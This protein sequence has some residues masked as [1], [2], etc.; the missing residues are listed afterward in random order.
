MLS[1]EDVD[2]HVLG[3]GTTLRFVLLLVLV[4]ASSA[5][6]MEDHIIIRRFLGDPN[7]DILGCQLAAGFDPESTFWNTAFHHRNNQALDACV[8]NYGPIWWVPVLVIA[9]LIA[10]TGAL[11]WCLPAWKGRRSRV[12]PV[13]EVDRQ[14]DLRPLLA[15]LVSLAGL[16]RAPHFVVD[17]AT[18]ATS[19]VVFG[20][21][22]RHTVCLHGGLVAR[23]LVDPAGFRGIV[24]HELAHIRNGDVGITYATVALW[25]VFLVAMLLPY[26]A[27]L[28][29]LLVSGQFFTTDS[30]SGVAWPAIVPGLTRG[31]LLSVF[32]VVLVYLSRADILRSREIHADLA[33]VGWGA[34]PEGWHHGAHGGADRSRI[35]EI[36]ASFT[37]LWHTHPRWDRRRRSLTDPSE[38]FGVPAL[39][40]FLT[41][42]AAALVAEHLRFT[43]WSGRA[44]A[45]MAAGLI[46][47]TV[48][49]ALWRAV[50]HAVLTDRRV[51]SG[52][53]AGMWLG[54]GLVAG[55]LLLREGID[56][57]QW[58]PSYPMV[59]LV[60][61]LLAV[62]ATCWTVQC[63]ELWITMSRGRLVRLT[64][65][66]GLVGMWGVVAAWLTWWQEMRE[67]IRPE[68]FAIVEQQLGQIFPRA[69]TTSSD[70]LSTITAGTAVAM[71]FGP[72]LVW[73]S[74]V[75]WLVPLLA[76]IMPSGAEPPPRRSAVEGLP[77]LRRVLLAAVLGGV[78]SWI[79][80][81]VVTTYVHSWPPPVDALFVLM[82]AALLLMAVTIGP[83]A[84]AAVM[85]ALPGNYRLLVASV[86]TGVAALI[87]IAGMFLLVSF[88]GCFGQL[89]IGTSSCGWWPDIGWSITAMVLPQ[90]LGPGVLA[91]VV[92]ALIAMEVANLVRGLA[93]RGAPPRP[94]GQRT[95]DRRGNLAVRRICVICVVALGL[96][97]TAQA[98]AQSVGVTTTTQVQAQPASPN[99]LDLS[100]AQLETNTAASSPSAKVR[101]AQ[102][103]AWYR[104]GGDD[105]FAELHQT[106]RN[107]SDAAGEFSDLEPEDTVTLRSACIKME[108][109]TKKAEAYFIIPDPQQESVWSQALTQ[110]KNGSV[111]CQ[112]ALN[113]RN[114]P[115]LETSLNELTEASQL[116]TSVLEW[117]S[118]QV[119]IALALQADGW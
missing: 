45:V 15:H 18:S 102:A 87:G 6:M 89:S 108:Q 47:G 22:G 7:N 4:T 81:A 82:Y 105:L 66:L 53:R 68:Y 40:A 17:P 118:V 93:R 76:W 117:L 44:A 98:Q 41:G 114:G 94:G 57:M 55:G 19:A 80:V 100:S 74:A 49:I 70:M 51:P 38:L 69:D 109:W 52:L 101:T 60:L 9:L 83:V 30:I 31:V 39:P 5:S 29:E 28:V 95:A 20:R 64:A 13:E 58:L 59:L 46:T 25:R 103:V 27:R 116:A 106:V 84:A 43:T 79:A 91:G 92:A 104:Y 23:R 12:V 77:S 35:G 112:N 90:L 71:T 119:E 65:V 26:V 110:S 42:V 48:G 72:F 88:N 96:A 113:E 3:A 97:A 99:Q 50:A 111:H 14:G 75:L 86:T 24:L 33:A 36:L 54:S 61:V 115:L 78:S 73:V 11:Y 8:D 32:T 107:I 34:A 1:R 56:R 85:G 10:A 63:A 16:H 21:P 62:V 67:L 37:D 2:I